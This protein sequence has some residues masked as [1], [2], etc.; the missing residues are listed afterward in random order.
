[1]TNVA[2]E[3][4]RTLLLEDLENA[5]VWR[6]M[7]ADEHSDD[8]RDEAAVGVLLRLC[9]YVRT[10]APEDER[11]E[12]V[13]VLMREVGNT[14]G[15]QTNQATRVGFGYHVPDLDRELNHLVEDAAAHWADLLHES[16]A[17]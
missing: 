15:F 2:N 5:A 17:T 14:S 8:P 11:L 12:R 1:M 4:A 3:K 10:L 16:D 6:A 7:K 13:A 9:E